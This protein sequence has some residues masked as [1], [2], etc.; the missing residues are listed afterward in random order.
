MTE[1][2]AREV[3]WPKLRTFVHVQSQVKLL[4]A[5]LPDLVVRSEC[6]VSRE[7]RLLLARPQFGQRE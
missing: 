2:H 5:S 4:V 3:P 7:H 6:F 1:I